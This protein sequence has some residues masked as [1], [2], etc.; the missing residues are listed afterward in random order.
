MTVFLLYKD[1]GPVGICGQAMSITS[2][3]QKLIEVEDTDVAYRLQRL[4]SL[5]LSAM[6]SFCG[7]NGSGGRK[8]ARIEAWFSASSLDQEM[9]CSELIPLPT[10][11][12]PSLNGS[13]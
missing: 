2:P 10:V 5:G 7:V 13:K 12:A 6:L 3:W 4:D 1:D 9:G 11:L 8:N